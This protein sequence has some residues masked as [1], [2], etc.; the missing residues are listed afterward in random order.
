MRPWELVGIDS[1]GRRVGL[2]EL[3]EHD[4]AALVT[5]SD[6]L[7][8]VTRWTDGRFEVDEQAKG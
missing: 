5:A 1:V 8:A 7:R 4:R 6:S 2:D 3:I